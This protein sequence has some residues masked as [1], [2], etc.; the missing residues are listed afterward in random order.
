[1]AC[2]E[3]IELEGDIPQLALICFLSKHGG[4]KNV[5]IMCNAPLDHTKPSW[6]WCRPFLPN[7]LTL[8][9]P[10]EVCCG[11]AEQ[12]CD[13][14]SLYKLEVEMSQLR[15]H[16][17]TFLCLLETLQHFW[18]LDHLGLQLVQS[19]PSAMP[20]SNLNVHDWDEYPAY[21]LK[22]IRVL[23]FFCSHG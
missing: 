19:L 2:L 10:L 23:S 6:S 22:Q 18:K 15:P 4:L 8:Y 7:L 5:R 16:D 1:M 12:I 14:S 20:E 17:P 13:L 3:D 9:A 21:K 11:I